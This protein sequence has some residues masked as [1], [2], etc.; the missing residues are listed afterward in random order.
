MS[1]FLHVTFGLVDGINNVR[2]RGTTAQIP[3][4]VLADLS[5]VFCVALM[6]A[7]N[8]GHYLSWCAVATLE[9]V[10]VD[11]GLLHGMQGAVGLCQTFYGCHIATFVHYG[12]AEARQDAAVVDQNAARTT[13]A[14][15]ATFF[16]SGQANMLTQ[17][18]EQCCAAIKGQSVIS[19]IDT[20]PHGNERI[21]IRW[22]LRLRYGFCV[23]A[24]Q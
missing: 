7:C 11:E 18:V 21:G 2:I 1:G 5:I 22:R 14:V 4:H 24:V 6:H 13:L 3:A 16:G 8:R 17:G 9:S 12:E 15:I 10:M 19:A 20:Q 23:R